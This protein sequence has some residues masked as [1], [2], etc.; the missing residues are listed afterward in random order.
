M[1]RIK[2]ASKLGDRLADADA[3]DISFLVLYDGWPE[4]VERFHAS[5]SAGVGVD[6]EL[7]V[8]DNPGDDEGSERIAVLDRTEH[9]PL[10][11]SV[12][13]GAGRNLAMR[14]ATGRILCVVDTSV[15]LTGDVAAPLLSSLSDPAIGL[16]GRWGVT[17][18]D[19]FHFDE[20]EGPDVDGVEGYLMALRRADVVRVGLFDPKFR[21]YRNADI[22]HSFRV[23][24]AGLRTIVDPS[25]PAS[26][27]EHRLW[28]STP[29]GQRDDLSHQNFHRFRRHWG[30]RPDLFVLGPP[31]DAGHTH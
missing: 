19:G 22:D 29:E 20:S 21:F 3:H 2:H 31:T 16:V 24:D 17:T 23:R 26:R 10:R 14:L 6:W 11:D 5:A 7:V 25:L 8:V 15:E 12:G 9:V 1:Q 4:D 30:D 28:E 18:R 13:Y 27:H